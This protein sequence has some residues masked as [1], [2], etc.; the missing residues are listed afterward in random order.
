MVAH[1]VLIWG[2]PS[3][4]VPASYAILFSHMSSSPA[5]PSSVAVRTGRWF[6]ED[7]HWLVRVFRSAMERFYWD[8]DFSKAAALAYTTLFSLVPVLVLL[9]AILATV[10]TSQQHLPG[11]QEFL[12]RQFVP[13]SEVVDAFIAQLSLV[14]DRMA[15]LNEIVLLVVV[16]SVFILINSIEG[17]LNEVWQ[18]YEPRTL[19]QRLQIYSAI[20]VVAPILALSGYWFV[21][22]RLRDFL[23]DIS[24]LRG[25]VDFAYRQLIPFLIDTAAF[26]SLFYLVPRAAVRFSSALAGAAVA[27]VLLGFAKWGFAVYIE[28]FASYNKVY[29]TLA[30]VPVFLFWLYLMW[31][32]ILFGAEVSYQAQHLP[33]VGSLW[34]R[35]VSTVGDGALLL[36]VQALSLIARRFSRG[37]RLPNDLEL[38]EALGVSYVVLK[39][40]LVSLMQGGFIARSEGREGALSLLRSPELI[41]VDEL[42]QLLFDGRRTVE[43]TEELSEV[44]TAL[45]DRREVTLA[46]LLKP[47]SAS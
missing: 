40:V 17:V 42:L 14:R 20:V 25:L 46:D 43:A 5:S 38:A 13:S 22:L 9:F 10:A 12:F 15:G 23:D 39:P 32:T 36:A 31:V 37:E 29:G 24:L 1:L 44:F 4:R 34:K 7:L 47:V 45:R 21:S 3:C 11:L 19:S 2:A 41:R 33:R 30:G 18:V 35:S 27:A 26:A 8:G 28:D 6:F 16:V